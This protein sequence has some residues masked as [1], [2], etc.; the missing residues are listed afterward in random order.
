MAKH[1]LVEQVQHNDLTSNYDICF[2]GGTLNVK[3]DEYKNA[4][5]TGESELSY[6]GEINLA[7]LNS[8][9]R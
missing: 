1:L 8:F 9:T 3:I 6:I 2:P 7:D 5:L 4:V